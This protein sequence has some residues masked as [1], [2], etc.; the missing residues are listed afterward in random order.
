[1]LPSSPTA[2]KSLS[3]CSV[4]RGSSSTPPVAKD[5]SA[6][7]SVRIRLV[8]VSIFVGRAPS[9]NNGWFSVLFSEN[10]TIVGRFRRLLAI[11][12]NG[13][14]TVVQFATPVS[15]RE[16]VSEDLPPERIVRKLSRVLRTHFNRIREAVIGPD[17][18]TRRLLIDK[19]LSSDPVKQAI[20]DTA[21]RENSKQEDAWK[22][23]QAYAYEIAADYSHPV[24][25]SASFL[26]TSVWN[27]IYRGVLVHHL[28][29]LKAS[30]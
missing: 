27:R 5:A 15:L 1:M 24:V 6:D 14:D 13:R 21:R 18:S 7:P 23:A 29:A 26:L 17:L 12:L 30:T 9:R 3:D 25:R 16:V 2:P 8:P 28:D 11:L 20:A 22:K 19:V 4:V 10:W